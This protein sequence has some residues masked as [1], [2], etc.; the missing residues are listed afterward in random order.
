MSTITD[1]VKYYLKMT[2]LEVE[3]FFCNDIVNLKLK[4]QNSVLMI[5]ERPHGKR[6]I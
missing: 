3:F 5:K 1:F 4:D 2:Y 6:K